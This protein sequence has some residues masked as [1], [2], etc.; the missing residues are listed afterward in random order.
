MYSKNIEMEKKSRKKIKDSDKLSKDSSPEY[1]LNCHILLNH[2][3][4][5]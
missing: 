2:L 5:V 4:N 1:F 3:A